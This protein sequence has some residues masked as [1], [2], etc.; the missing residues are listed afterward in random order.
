[1]RASVHH[2]RYCPQ[3]KANVEPHYR[4]CR[5]CFFW[6]AGNKTPEIR[7]FDPKI[8]IDGGSAL[9][10]FWLSLGIFQNSFRSLSSGIV[11]M[12]I[13]ALTLIIYS[14]I[15][16]TWARW[17][18]KA[19]QASCYANMR[20]IQAAIEA[21][22]NDFRF[23]PELASDPAHLLFRCGYLRNHPQCPVLGN[24]YKIPRGSRLQCVGSESHGL[25][26]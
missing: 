20:V 4:F 6:L 16:P 3:C 21:Y 5:A 25:S 10:R 8:N 19:R 22:V 7:S 18:P 2:Y 1:M 26:Q 9:S 13:L 11:I 24:V 12:A 15:I 17:G 23:T 14:W